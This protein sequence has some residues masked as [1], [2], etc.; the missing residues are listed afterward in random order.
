MPPTG[1][2]RDS[3]DDRH[4]LPLLARIVGV[5][6]NQDLVRRL[7]CFASM[8]TRWAGLTRYAVLVSPFTT[9]KLAGRSGV[10]RRTAPFAT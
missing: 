7:D 4:C 1:L 9:K 6:R 5:G 8:K 10:S 3:G 2:V